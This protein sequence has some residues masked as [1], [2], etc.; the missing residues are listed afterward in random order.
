VVHQQAALWAKHMLEAPGLSAAERIDAMYVRT[1]ARPPRPE[2]RADCLDFLS[3]QAEARGVAP[4]DPVV[5]ADL[6]HVL[7]NLK[8]FI[9]LY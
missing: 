9:F 3:R 7:F 1:I 6:A 8:E 2:E 5:W 4:D